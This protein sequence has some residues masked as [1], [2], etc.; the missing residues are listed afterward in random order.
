FYFWSHDPTGRNPL[1]PDMCNYLGL[2]F[3]LS[4]KVNY[5]QKAWPTEVYKILHDNQIL[6]GFDP[7]T[8]DFAR[9]MEYPTWEVVPPEDRCQELE[10]SIR[11]F[12][13]A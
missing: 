2:P 11:F 12:G 7:R 3:E 8:T 6:R 1:S 9:Y 10:G 5:W 13:P 4:L